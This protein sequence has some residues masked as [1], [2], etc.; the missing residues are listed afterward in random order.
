MRV[1]VADGSGEASALVAALEEAGFAARAM[2]PTDVA[3][4]AARDLLLLAGDH[5]QALAILDRVRSHPAASVLP[6]ILLGVPPAGPSDEDTLRRLGADA[7]YARPAPIA[8]VVRRVQAFLTPAEQIRS[9]PDGEGA[10]AGPAAAD[11]PP[12]RS[13]PPP[14]PAAPVPT[15]ALARDQD[16]WQ[17]DSWHDPEAPG[18]GR[19]LSA[20][21]MA[22]L[23]AA[24]ERLFPDAPEADLS[25]ADPGPML[26]AFL[27]EDLLVPAPLPEDD[28]PGP[29][30]EEAASDAS[31]AG[32]APGPELAA[33]TTVMARGARGHGAR[34]RARPTDESGVSSAVDR[35]QP[36]LES[37]LGADL[38]AL[39]VH[40]ARHLITRDEARQRLGGEGR[41]RLAPDAADRLAGLRLEP[42]LCAWMEGHDGASL[43]VL[44]EKEAPGGGGPGLLVALAALQ[45]LAVHRMEQERPGLGDLPRAEARGLV[46]AAHALAEEGDYFSVLGVAPDAAQPEL[47]AAYGNRRQALMSV[48]GLDEE[49]GRR[50]QVALDVLEEAYRILSVERL[51]LAYRRALTAPGDAPP[52]LPPHAPDARDS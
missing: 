4:E 3:P 13:A 51:R 32:S 38:P 44:L 5:E 50:R 52:P 1:D 24:D 8:R 42:E 46:A 19:G 45:I 14:A 39:V 49:L 12:E 33:A 11:L 31:G 36:L 21:V 34:S 26:E 30:P 37:E 9:H 29:A 7:V 48:T 35:I 41:V 16:S 10:M 28:A 17:L 23:R 18:A 22:L 15:L 43:E 20:E 6:I 25:F 40:G 2:A 47:D 27:R